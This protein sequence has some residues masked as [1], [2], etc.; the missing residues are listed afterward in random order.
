MYTKNMLLFAILSHTNP[1]RTAQFYLYN[2]LI[3]KPPLYI[4]V[5]QVVSLLQIPI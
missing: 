5:F 2:I 4:L 1:V 3:I